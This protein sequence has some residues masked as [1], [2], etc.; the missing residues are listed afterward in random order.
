MKPIAY[1]LALSL[2]FFVA[3]C[4][5]DAEETAVTEETREMPA[6]A[7]AISEAPAAPSTPVTL[8]TLNDSG[9]GGDVLLSAEGGSTHLTGHLTGATEGEEVMGHVHR[10]TCESMQQQ[11]SSM[12]EFGPLAVGPGGTVTATLNVPLQEL[13]TGQHAIGFH[14]GEGTPHIACAD[15]HGAM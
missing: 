6:D 5:N 12:G 15:F 9:I 4:G 1:L 2:P 11:L 13:N 10:G 3:S 8:Q 14:R 7:P